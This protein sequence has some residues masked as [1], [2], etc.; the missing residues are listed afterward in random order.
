ML[1]L[2]ANIVSHTST[3]AYLTHTNILTYLQAFIHPY[4]HTYV[5]IFIHTYTHTCIHIYMHT[6][7]HAYIHTYVRTYMRNIKFYLETN[8]HQLHSWNNFHTFFGKCFK[9]CNVWIKCLYDSEF[10]CYH[11]INQL[12][13]QKPKRGAG[14]NVCH[15]VHWF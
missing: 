7:I 8:R 9:Y 2:P 3:L 1:Y 4:A 15:T 10:L 12:I 13:D 11:Q 6:Y 5:H 14:P